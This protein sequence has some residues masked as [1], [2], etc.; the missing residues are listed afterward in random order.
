M[1]SAYVC[2][3]FVLLGNVKVMKKTLRMLAHKLRNGFITLM[4]LHNNE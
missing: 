1:L 2:G 3:V 4:E